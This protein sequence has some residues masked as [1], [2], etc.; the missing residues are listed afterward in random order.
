MNHEG[1]RPTCNVPDCGKVANGPRGLCAG[2]Y[3]RA[4][5]G[6]AGDP[7][8]EKARKYML[9]SKKGQ[10]GGRKGPGRK[11]RAWNRRPSGPGPQRP[12]A[13]GEDDTVADPVVDAVIGTVTEFA[14][15]M[16]LVRVELADAF[17]FRNEA[18]GA[19]VALMKNG[20]LRKVDLTFG[21]VLHRAS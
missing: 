7:E 11:G 9:A 4:R 10:G 14:S 19:Q 1:N 18:T 5:K 21:D 16:G 17:L 8:A 2:H 6:L 13:A 15:A 20:T 3:F 12:A